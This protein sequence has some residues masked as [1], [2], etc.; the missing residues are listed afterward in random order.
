MCRMTES[1][2]LQPVMALGQML[3]ERQTQLL[4]LLLAWSGIHFQALPCTNWQWR[5][6]PELPGDVRINGSGVQL[7]SSRVGHAAASFTVG[8]GPDCSPHPAGLRL[9]GASSPSRKPSS[10]GWTPSP[11]NT[12]FGSGPSGWSLL[13]VPSSSHSS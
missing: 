11:R 13:D 12:V 9:G 3:G 4:Q 6:T 1:Q 5:M 8:G 7:A 10:T 2:Q